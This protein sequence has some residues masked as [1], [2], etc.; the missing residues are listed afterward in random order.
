MAK[1]RFSLININTRAP[2]CDIEMDSALLEP[3]AMIMNPN[4][5]TL[6]LF[7][8]G[9]HY[10]LVPYE[11]DHTDVVLA[12]V[13]AAYK[14]ITEK[15]T[16]MFSTAIGRMDML[17]EAV[18]LLFGEIDYYLVENPDDMNALINPHL[19]REHKK[20]K[21]SILKSLRNKEEPT[22][23]TEETHVHNADGSCCK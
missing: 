8:G 3:E 7:R 2:V 5:F 22:K 9:S 18:G 11:N 23:E 21:Y 20:V 14:N 16:G 13:E 6:D 1:S 19:N 10:T 15:P 17:L 4:T 12:K